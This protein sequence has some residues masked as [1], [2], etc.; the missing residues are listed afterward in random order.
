MHHPTKLN[1]V[2][3]LFFVLVIFFSFQTIYA[4]SEF[5]LDQAFGGEWY[6]AEKSKGNRDDDWLCWASSAANVL[7]WTGWGTDAGFKTEDDIFRYYSEH[8]TDHPSGSPRRAW[9]WWFTGAGSSKKGAKVIK[10]GG[11]FWPDVEFP[12][13][14]WKSPKGALFRGIG[15]NKLKRDPYILRK[16]L[17]EG[18]GVALQIV[19]PQ[20]DGERN[21]HM[22]TL[23]GFRYDNNNPFKGILI[24]DSDD[25]KKAK[26]AEEADNK[27][28][29]YPVTL[30][31]E[32]WWFEYKGKQWK[33]LAAYALQAK[34]KKIH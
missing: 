12:T 25:D 33:I 10:E 4:D 28:P 23:W 26:T 32:Y 15:K 30:R 29:Y 20:D 27:L 21:S 8:W 19:Q 6:D 31:D 22:I 13:Y 14:K 34:N 3:R 9:Q 24:T 2:A 16:L 11:A 1:R 18:Y 5:R 17:E 7:A